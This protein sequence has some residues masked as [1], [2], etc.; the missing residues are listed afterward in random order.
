M[1]TGENSHR[2]LIVEP[3]Q[4]SD[5]WQNLQTFQR[6]AYLVRLHFASPATN[7]DALTVLTVPE[8]AEDSYKDL[9]V[10]SAA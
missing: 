8:A 9:V 5:D 6:H 10:A 4:E 1:D 3:G 7:A 2:A